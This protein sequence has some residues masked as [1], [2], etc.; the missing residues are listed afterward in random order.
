MANT[1]FWRRVD[2]PGM[3]WARLTEAGDW[4]ELR[5]TVILIEEGVPARLDY[6]I[7]CNGRWETQR[8]EVSGWVRDTE[9]NLF[10]GRLASGEWELNGKVISAVAGCSDI[11][12]AFSPATN[13]LPIRRLH[14]E[15]NETGEAKAAWLLFPTLQLQPMG[16]R[17]RR[18][19]QGHYDYAADTGFAAR[20]EVHPTGWVT[21]YPPFW[22]AETVRQSEI[23]EIA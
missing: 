5:G 14:L 4:A 23:A 1:V 2:C 12:F 16:Q 8:A 6:S 3:E 18:V 15:L 21:D 22:R 9:I 13:L 11:D 19:G 7:L 17:F 20:L 10:I